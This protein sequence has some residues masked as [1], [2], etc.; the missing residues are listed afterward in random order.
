MNV[1]MKKTPTEEQKMNNYADLSAQTGL[2]IS[3]IQRAHQM[4]V[5]FLEIDWPD[6]TH[7]RKVRIWKGILEM[8]E[9]HP[10][11][12]D[13]IC[14]MPTIEH[15]TDLK[16]PNEALKS[17]IIAFG[18][19][20]CPYYFTH[21][22]E[23]VTGE[24]TANPD[25][26]T[27]QQVANQ[28]TQEWEVLLEEQREQ[29]KLIAEEIE[30]T[31]SGITAKPQFDA[32]VMLQK[33]QKDLPEEDNWE[34]IFVGYDPIKREHSYTLIRTNVCVKH[35]SEEEETTPFTPENRFLGAGGQWNLSQD[36]KQAL[37]EA[38]NQYKQPIHSQHQQIIGSLADKHGPF[39]RL[40]TLRLSVEYPNP[41]F[42]EESLKSEN[43]FIRRKRD[44]QWSGIYAQSQIEVES[45]WPEDFD[46]LNALRRP[47]G[48]AVMNFRNNK[49]VLQ[50][51]WQIRSKWKLQWKEVSEQKVT[52]L[53]VVSSGGKTTLDFSDTGFHQGVI[54]GYN[55]VSA[56]LSDEQSIHGHLQQKP[57]VDQTKWESTIDFS[58]EELTVFDG[59][60]KITLLQ[61]GESIHEDRRRTLRK[62]PSLNHN[63]ESNVQTSGEAF[64]HTVEGSFVCEQKL[65]HREQN[66]NPR[67]DYQ[68]TARVDWNGISN[69]KIPISRNQHL[70]VGFLETN[71]VKSKA[72]TNKS[73]IGT[74]SI[75]EIKWDIFCSHKTTSKVHTKQVN[76][77]A[78]LKQDWLM[79]ASAIPQSTKVTLKTEH[80][81]KAAGFGIEKRP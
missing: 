22:L 15:L 16:L 61:H 49:R 8:A 6:L 77:L 7:A 47:H 28:V 44:F 46:L 45:R 67:T 48:W 21:Q 53:V 13:R 76:A 31:L 65:H 42:R 35:P 37:L 78:H 52:P 68:S 1:R 17:V 11:D 25:P 26:E 43:I 38:S 73:I 14:K 55:G 66:D 51:G 79:N 58:T 19:P 10:E 39:D 74:I 27:M 33:L 40:F 81:H 75:G 60:S 50:E 23:K 24:K 5:T 18:H 3:M 59:E 71:D 80:G 69:I 54:S 12:A 4:L 36:E 32:T 57:T 30:E 63:F 72:P 29:E 2:I 70:D 20:E 34:V 64:S 62:T 56:M 9:Q 41:S